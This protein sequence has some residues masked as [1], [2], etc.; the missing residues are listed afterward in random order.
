MNSTNNPWELTSEDYEDYDAAA[1]DAGGGGDFELLPK[2][3]YV[4][5]VVKA[6][7]RRTKAGDGEYLWLEIDIDDG[8]H[9]GRK[10]WDRLNLVNRNP[11]AVAIARRSFTALCASTGNTRGIKS[12][13]DLCFKRFEFRVGVQAARGDYPASN[14]VTGYKLLDNAVPGAIH[15]PHTPGAAA[16]PVTQTQRPAAAPPRVS[17][18]WQ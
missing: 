9:K 7:N 5:V 12:P 11:Q 6:E 18:G 14:N 2:G 1:N 10:V 8:Q 4:G 17:G 13:E 3:W 16:Q 15:P